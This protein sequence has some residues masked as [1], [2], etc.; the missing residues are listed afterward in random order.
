MSTA[1]RASILRLL[2]VYQ[3]TTGCTGCCSSCLSC[4]HAPM[5]KC[6]TLFKDLSL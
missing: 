2:S 3:S 5:L 4:G 6:N 1:L